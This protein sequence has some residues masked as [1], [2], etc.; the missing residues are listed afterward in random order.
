MVLYFSYKIEDN[1]CFIDAFR[2]SEIQEDNKLTILSI[3]K[4]CY[5]S[6]VKKF[7]F[8]A[9][10]LKHAHKKYVIENLDLSFI[11]EEISF[12]IN[13]GVNIKSTIIC[14]SK[15]NIN[16]RNVN[17]SIAQKIVE[18]IIESNNFNFNLIVT[19]I[20]FD[21]YNDYYEKGFNIIPKVVIIPGYY[22]ED[23][24]IKK[25]SK[26]IAQNRY[27]PCKKFKRKTSYKYIFDNNT[28]KLTGSELSKICQP[29]DFKKMSI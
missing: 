3:V 5:E 17:Y 2:T 29:G 19:K 27:F 21:K 23:G 25:L 4:C 1:E 10:N 18:N 12:K 14:N 28:R 8:T 26:K 20:M 6:G 7:C 13:S 15:I 9:N 11:R 16:V 24:I 22:I